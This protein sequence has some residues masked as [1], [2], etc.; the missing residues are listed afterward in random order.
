[1]IQVV[2]EIAV[3]EGGQAEYDFLVERIPNVIVDADR[4]KIIYGLAASQDKDRLV[5]LLNMT[6][7]NIAKYLDP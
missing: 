5:Q 3:R 7:R 2:Y 1:M 6:V 4:I